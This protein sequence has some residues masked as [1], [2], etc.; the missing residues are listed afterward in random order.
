MLSHFKTL[1]VISFK[2]QWLHLF[3]INTNNNSIPYFLIPLL[4]SI[5]IPLNFSEIRWI[6][7]GTLLVYNS[8]SVNSYSCA[9]ISIS[10]GTPVNLILTAGLPVQ[11]KSPAR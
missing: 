2:Y 9:H 5:F 6:F 11:A 7:R 8:G 10:E 1:P 3:Q 4:F